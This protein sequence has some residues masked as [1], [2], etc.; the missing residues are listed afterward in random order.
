MRNGGERPAATASVVFDLVTHIGNA[1]GRAGA[2]PRSFPIYER[3]RIPEEPGSV[4][5]PDEVNVFYPHPHHR[6]SPCRKHRAIL[7]Q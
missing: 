3:R 6:R 5:G 7:P 4:I 2:G 1:A